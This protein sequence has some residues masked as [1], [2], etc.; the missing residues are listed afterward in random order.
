[1]STVSWLGSAWRRQST[2]L[3]DGDFPWGAIISDPAGY[4]ATQ[5]RLI[6]YP[7]GITKRDR[8]WLRAWRGWPLWG[9]FL[10]FLVQVCLQQVMS[11]WPATMI[12]CI[13]CAAVGLAAYVMAGDTRR[14]VR[15][16]NGCVF[17]AAAS[18]DLVESQRAF[19]LLTTTLVTAHAQ[20]RRGELS[21]VDYE[22]IWW[23]V[24]DAMALE[25]GT[26]S[27]GRPDSRSN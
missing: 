12:S 25:S 10:W 27:G 14:Q 11:P 21:T 13:A 22:R 17:T 26:T 8:R 2:A 1:V 5:Q 19:R 7:P 6:V 18:P 24:Y 9:G 3:L 15:T 4:D 16:F 20:H 23:N